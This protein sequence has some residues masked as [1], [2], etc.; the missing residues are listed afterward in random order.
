M[1]LKVSASFA[2]VVVVVVP[3]IMALTTLAE[4]AVVSPTRTA[5][6][7]RLANH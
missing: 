7:S 4:V 2:L 6:L 1:A 3:E 5:S